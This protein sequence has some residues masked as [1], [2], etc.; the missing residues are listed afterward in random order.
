MPHGHTAGSVIRRLTTTILT[1]TTQEGV[2]RIGPAYQRHHSHGRIPLLHYA[3]G[4]V[5]CAGVE[6]CG[7]ADSLSMTLRTYSGKLSFVESGG[8]QAKEGA[9]AAKHKSRGG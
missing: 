9:S 6:I 8:V 5:S 7:R 4:C 1:L 2:C 3:K